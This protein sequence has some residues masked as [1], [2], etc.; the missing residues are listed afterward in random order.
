MRNKSAKGMK[1][2]TLSSLFMIILVQGTSFSFNK[3]LEITANE[4]HVYLKPDTN[5]TKVGTLKKGDMVTLASATK[6]KKI[7]HYVYFCPENSD[8]TSSGYILESSVKK[9]FNVTKVLLIQEGKSQKYRH[10]YGVDFRNTRWGMSLQQVIF[11]EGE[12]VSREES[13]GSATLKYKSELMDMDCLLMYLFSKNNLIKAKYNFLKKYPVNSQYIEEHSSIKKTLIE[14]YG[15]PK[16]EN[17][18]TETVHEGNHS[19]SKSSLPNSPKLLK[20]TCW[21]TSET[22]VCLNLYQNKE[23]INLE[24]EYSGLKFNNFGI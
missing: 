23:H 8:F 7:W 17:I 4:A 15:E 10:E 14:K 6:I 5:S 3:K 18:Y 24:L 11:T 20:T 9:L 13:N 19:T 1:W 22:R 21:E 16:Q 12:P 2:I